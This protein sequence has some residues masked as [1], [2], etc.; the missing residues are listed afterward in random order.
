MEGSVSTR[1]RILVSD[2]V[3]VIALM[4][5]R[6]LTEQ[7]YEVELAHDGEECL[8]KVASFRPELMILDLMMPKVHGIDILKALRASEETKNIGVIVFSSKSFTTEQ[9]MAEELGAFAFVEKTRDTG[10][11]VELVERY[12]STRDA[13]ASATIKVTGTAAA[14][15]YK[16]TLDENQ[17]TFKLWGTRGSIPIS[18]AEFTRHGGNTS[19]MDVRAGDE[20]IVFDAGSGI[21]NL[22]ASLMPKGARKIHLFITHTHWDHIQGFPFFIPAFVPGFEVTIYGAKGFGKDL[23]SIF[24]GQLDSD[25]FPVQLEDMR[26]TL[27]FVT[28]TEQKV[29]VG[30]YEVQW[31]YTNHPGAAIAY[32]AVING[33][34]VVWMPDNEFAQGY[35]GPPQELTLDHPY[36]VPHLPIVDFLRGA[37]VVIGE[38]QYMNDEYPKKIGWGHT[39]LSNGCALMKLAGVKRW[40]VTH[41]D[42]VHTDDFLE[43]KIALTRQIFHELCH[44][45][46]VDLAYDG[47]VGYLRDFAEEPLRSVVA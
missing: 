20:L 14:T 11:L 18:G 24:R 30:P 12:F 6:A 44:P 38:S 35:I 5:G 23:E 15:D 4:V 33:T 42:P 19:C 8:N 26:A 46:R 40:L 25:Y 32:K 21:R 13:T 47:M 3:R 10:V 17:S 45:I 27:R 28:M 34:T 31:E 43:R 37:D 22:G 29:T 16:P 9:R 2:D 1:H 7:G 36:V 39:M 41:H